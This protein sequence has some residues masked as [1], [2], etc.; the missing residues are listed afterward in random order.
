MLLAYC[1]CYCLPKPGP[2][3]GAATALPNMHGK[4]DFPARSQWVF[5]GFHK[6]MFLVF[7]LSENPAGQDL[8]LRE[9]ACGAWTLLPSLVPWLPS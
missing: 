4:K 6:K 7:S 8:R 5:V 2:I 9:C 1:Y 3:A